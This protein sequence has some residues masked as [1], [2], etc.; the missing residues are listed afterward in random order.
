M[1]GDWIKMTKDLP[2]KPEVWQMA[3][4]LN[5]DAD[6]VVGKLLRVWSWFDAHTEDG[7]AHGVS[8]PL[9]DR[10]AGVIGFAEAMFLAGWLEQNGTVLTLPKFARHNG[11]TGK[12]RALTNERVAKHRQINDLA[13][14]DA[15]NAP[16]VTKTVTREEKRREEKTNT[17][18][19]KRAAAARLVSVSELVADGVEQQAAEDW[20]TNRKAKDLPLTPTAWKQTKDEA[21]KAGLTPAQAVSVAAGNGWAGFKATW[22]ADSAKSRAGQSPMSDKF[23]GAL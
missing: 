19:R 20:L 7:N 14:T 6:C 22:A 21:T 5:V 11:K 3:G 17:P 8:F 1:A 12:N 15:C 4:A 23:A 18:A 10:V 16:S 9:I 13:N 2:D